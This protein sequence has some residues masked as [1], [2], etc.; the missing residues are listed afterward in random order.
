MPFQCTTTRKL[1]C[2]YKLLD[3]SL[4]FLREKKFVLKATP[5]FQTQNKYKFIFLP[6]LLFCSLV[7]LRS[8]QQCFRIFLF[9]SLSLF[10]RINSLALHEKKLYIEV[11]LC[12]FFFSLFSIIL[13][14]S[15]AFL[16]TKTFHL[17]AV[18]SLRLQLQWLDDFNATAITSISVASSSLL[19]HS[20]Y[21]APTSQLTHTYNKHICFFTAPVAL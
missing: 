17:F 20:L 13:S 5:F 7:F 12:V 14:F 10:L 9:F 18:C 2:Q 1:L 21:L 15:G 6:V 3:I 11:A 19:L 8:L 16:Q 4:E